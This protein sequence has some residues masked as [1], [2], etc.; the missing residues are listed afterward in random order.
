[1]TA[2][3][4]VARRRPEVDLDVARELLGEAATLLHDGLAFDGLDAHDTD[5]VV[6]GLCLALVTQDPGI[7]VRAESDAASASPALHDPEG[8][9]VAYLM[10]VSILRL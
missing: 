4:E 6:A 7:A 3:E 9:S 2:A 10:A 1:M 8:A 5:A